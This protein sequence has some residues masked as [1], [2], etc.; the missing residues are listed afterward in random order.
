[1]R[2]TDNMAMIDAST[3]RFMS[4]SATRTANYYGINLLTSKMKSHKLRVYW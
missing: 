2:T 4:K 3:Q 1:M